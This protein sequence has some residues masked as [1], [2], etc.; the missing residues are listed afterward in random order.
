MLQSQN[1]LVYVWMGENAVDK[2]FVFY[3]ECKCKY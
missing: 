3:Y 2:F 1:V